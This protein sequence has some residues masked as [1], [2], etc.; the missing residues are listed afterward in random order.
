M[1]LG[2]GFA[3][4]ARGE[5]FRDERGAIS[6]TAQSLAEA[7]AT[8]ESRIDHDALVVK[9]EAR[10]DR[11][12]APVFGGPHDGP[13]GAPIGAERQTIVVLGAVASF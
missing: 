5:L 12:T 2:H 4:A 6:G 11:S 3:A 9:L 7:T 1:K 8:I 10:H 13:T